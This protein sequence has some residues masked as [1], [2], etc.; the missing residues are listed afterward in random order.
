[1]VTAEDKE[2]ATCLARLAE[3]AC[4]A[5]FA[6]GRRHVC[7]KIVY[8]QFKIPNGNGWFAEVPVNL[9]ENPKRVSAGRVAESLGLVPTKAQTPS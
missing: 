3:G 8:N 9:P 5:H 4:D 1:M 7:Q 6:N 2:N